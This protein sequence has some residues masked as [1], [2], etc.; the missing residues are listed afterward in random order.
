MI[1]LFIGIGLVA[2]VVQYLLLQKFTGSVTKD[3]GKSR[4]RGVAFALAQFLFPF[5]VLVACALIYADSLMWV[6]IGIASSL[7]VCAVIKFIITSKKNNAD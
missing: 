2:G 4:G 1:G 7:I 3:Q 5:V 6:G